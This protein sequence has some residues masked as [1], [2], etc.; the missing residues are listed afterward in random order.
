MGA[1]YSGFSVTRDYNYGELY[2]AIA[3]TNCNA[4]IHHSPGLFGFARSLFYVK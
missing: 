1:A 3:T 2:T 4:R